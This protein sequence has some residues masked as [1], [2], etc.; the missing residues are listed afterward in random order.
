MSKLS[1]R[2]IRRNPA[3]ITS[4]FDLHPGTEVALCSLIPPIGKLQRCAQAMVG[5]CAPPK[6]GTRGEN[7]RRAYQHTPT[8][9]IVVD[10][11]ATVNWVNVPDRS[12]SFIVTQHSGDQS[13]EEKLKALPTSLDAVPAHLP[14]VP[15]VRETNFQGEPVSAFQLMA[16]FEDVGLASSSYG[17]GRFV[18]RLVQNQ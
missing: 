3:V 7:M 10:S 12:A 2:K 6:S 16:G 13:A 17:W 15:A 9:G 11:V 18:L 14:A 5:F 1:M 8:W 4:P